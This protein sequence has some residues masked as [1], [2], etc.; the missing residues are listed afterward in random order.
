MYCVSYDNN[1]Y[2]GTLVL[3][4]Y[5]CMWSFLYREVFVWKKKNWTRIGLWNLVP[6]ETRFVISCYYPI[7]ISYLTSFK[8]CLPAS[9]V[10][11]IPHSWSFP[12]HSWVQR[13]I[14][15]IT[16]TYWA[17]EPRCLCWKLRPVKRTFRCREDWSPL[18]CPVLDVNPLDLIG[19][20]SLSHYDLVEGDS[21]SHYSFASHDRDF[22]YSLEIKKKKSF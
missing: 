7:P 13:T 11:S 19:S 14:P 4:F 9:S 22:F 10:S 1:N 3:T 6:K 21:L 18:I 12:H 17:G 16:R 20:D 5:Y 2:V 8:L 15:Q